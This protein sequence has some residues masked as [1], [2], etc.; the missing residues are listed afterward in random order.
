[1]GFTVQHVHRPCKELCGIGWDVVTSE[2]FPIRSRRILRHESKLTQRNEHDAYPQQ[3]QFQQVQREKARQP[4][5]QGNEIHDGQAGSRAGEYRSENCGSDGQSRRRF[6]RTRR[7]DTC[8]DELRRGGMHDRN[9]AP[10]GTER[11]RHRLV[12][13]ALSSTV[14][15]FYR[16]GT[17]G[18]DPNEERRF[19]GRIGEQVL[20]RR[21]RIL[22]TQWTIGLGGYPVLEFAIVGARLIHIASHH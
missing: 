8:R 14:D 5:Q 4:D 9:A 1:M 21:V 11:Q 12:H 10:H 2:T 3:L 18:E 16:C 22:P 13:A 7:S 15:T 6:Q 20:Y 19:H 17:A